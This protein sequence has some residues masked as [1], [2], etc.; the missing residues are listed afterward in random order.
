MINW[1][2]QNQGVIGFVALLV[3]VVGFFITNQN[4]R[5]QKQRGGKGSVNQQAMDSGRNSVS[6]S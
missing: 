3:T 5:S 2:N 6:R 1:L 4:I